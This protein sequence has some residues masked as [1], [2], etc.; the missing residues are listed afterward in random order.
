MR[1]PRFSTLL[2]LC[3]LPIIPIQPALAAQGP[4]NERATPLV[5]PRLSGPITLDGF[6]DEPAWQAIAPLPLT[7]FM[8]IYRGTPTEHTEIR[9]AYDDNYL[10]VAGRMYDSEPHL[11]QATTYKRDNIVLKDDKIVIVLDTFNDNENALSF[12][13][14][15]AG[16]RTDLAIFNDAASV[17]SSPF[18][19]S[20]N[21]FWDAA[22]TQNS[23]G[24]F[25]EMRIPFSSLR[26][27][28]SQG[29]VVMG[30]SCFRVIAR[31]VEVVV[32]PDRPLKWELMGLWKPSQT[33]KVRLEGITP[34]KAGLHYSLRSGRA[35]PVRRPEPGR[36]GLRDC[37]HFG[38][39]HR[40]GRQV[41]PDQ[42]PHP[43]PD[44]QH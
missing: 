9:V 36:H 29:A 5:L 27:Q 38:Q 13:T 24:W 20:W 37:Q 2:L 32:F 3:S 43:G 17:G 19:L 41:R 11:I 42:Q 30:L 7:A 16:L 39:G 8:P 15:P 35:G 1:T 40:P 18:N 28:D 33:Q 4:D 21:T 10:Y 14:T 6:S 34:R 12:F 26:F 25:A 31:K 44:A 23:K 22:V